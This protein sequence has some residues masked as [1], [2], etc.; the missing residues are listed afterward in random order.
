MRMRKTRNEKRRIA[1]ETRSTKQSNQKKSALIRFPPP[2][3]ADAPVDPELDEEEVD[4]P[5]D[6]PSVDADDEVDDD[7]QVACE[8]LLL[9]PP[10]NEKK[11]KKN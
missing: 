9:P 1:E 11:I 6:L 2:E 10:P 7:D 5:V 3:V 4:F 8:S